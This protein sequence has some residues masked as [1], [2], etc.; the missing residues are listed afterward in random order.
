M[1]LKKNFG[2]WARSA[3]VGAVALALGAPGCSSDQPGLG[4]CPP[5]GAS[6]SGGSGGGGGGGGI[7][8]AAGDSSDAGEGQIGGVAGEG[9]DATSGKGGAS[10]KAGAGGS[11]G[12]AGS[13]GVGGSS[14]GTGGGA[15]TGGSG[16]SG[17]G[18]PKL[19][20]ACAEQC[21]VIAGDPLLGTDGCLNGPGVAQAGPAKSVALSVLCTELLSCLISSKC[22]SPAHDI[23]ECY[24]GMAAAECQTPGGAKGPCVSEIEAAA[25]SDDSVDI[26]GR[27]G[28]PSYAL[29]RAKTV[30]D[31][32][33][34]NCPTTC[35]N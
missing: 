21:K 29:G 30:M 27:F 35:F 22:V 1:Q 17:G 15:G 26:T 9:G 3:V 31:C 19:C 34:E 28:D 7:T 13:D 18:G 25:E 16:G 4:S 32:Y 6:G 20:A 8:S 5:A 12:K 23:S 2:F 33:A 10:G 14:G 11:G 24:C